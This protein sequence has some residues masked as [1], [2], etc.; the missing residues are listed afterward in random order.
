MSG[1]EVKIWTDGSSTGKRGPGGWGAI[2]QYGEHERE[3][4]GGVHDTT[5]NE[6]EFQAVVEAIRVLKRPVWVLVITDSEL[7]VGG[8]SGAYDMEA[9][10]LIKLIDEFKRIVNEK[11]H[12]VQFMH[13]PGHA[14]IEDNERADKLAKA[15]KE[16]LEDAT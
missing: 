15:A 6:M 11:G 4:S 3:I 13:V 2:L 9:L 10:H 7:A 14:G 12:R 5:N 1:P 8:F 16:A